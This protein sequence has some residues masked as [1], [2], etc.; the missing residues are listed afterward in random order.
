MILRRR[1]PPPIMRAPALP[2]AIAWTG[3]GSPPFDRS[4]LCRCNRKPSTENKI[5]SAAPSSKQSLT[6][7]NSTR[8]LAEL[9]M[10]H[11]RVRV[12][13][14]VALLLYSRPS[15]RWEDTCWVF[16]KHEGA[17]VM[18]RQNQNCLFE[19]ILFK[20]SRRRLGTTELANAL[21]R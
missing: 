16:L 7:V 21:V 9:C 20:E 6:N 11:L 12:L 13:P 10:S 17:V 3:F 18:L 19:L 5:T 1:S 2:L 15:N 4:N 14:S 8:R